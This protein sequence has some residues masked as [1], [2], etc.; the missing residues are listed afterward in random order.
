MKVMIAIGGT[1][2]LAEAIID[3]ICF[4]ILYLIHSLY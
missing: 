4:V 1:V 2:G 3:D